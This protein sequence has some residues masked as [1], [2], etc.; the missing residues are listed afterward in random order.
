[1]AKTENH[2]AIWNKFYKQ[3]KALQIQLK[4]YLIT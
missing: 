2:W 4:E 1:M 3:K